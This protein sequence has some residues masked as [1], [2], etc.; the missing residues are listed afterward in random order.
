MPNFI[1]IDQSLRA[2]GVCVVDE[3]GERLRL[4]TIDTSGLHTVDA[5]AKVAQTVE[6]LIREFRPI[7]VTVEEPTRMAASASLV[8]LCELFGVIRYVAVCN[9]YPC[10]DD[11]Y[12]AT[13]RWLKVQN[14]S[15]MKKF[16]LGNG[17]ISKDSAYMLAVFK[18]TGVEFEDD[19]QADAAMHGM[20]VLRAWQIVSRAVSPSAFTAKQLSALTKIPDAKVGKMAAEDILTRLVDGPPPKRK[21]RVGRA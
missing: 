21:T 4:G 16:V 2:T 11:K 15:T 8:T 10:C 5:I 6:R 14:Q 3:T 7:Y 18:A 12:P 19:N 13:G 17:G 9:G 20:T 1:A